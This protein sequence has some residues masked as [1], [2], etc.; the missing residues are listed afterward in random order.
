M[1]EFDLSHIRPVEINEEAYRMFNV[2]AT[3]LVSATDG[4]ET[5]VMAATWC[6]N[7]DY[8]PT[9]LTVVLAKEHATRRLLENNP[10][11]EFLIQIPNFAQA[12]LTLAVGSVSMNDDAD[13]LAH[14]GV[15]LFD[16]AGKGRPFVK[17][18]CGWAV[19]KLIP[20][21]ANQQQYDLFIGE[22]KE[23]WADDRIFER[24]HW[25]FEF[26]DPQ[27]R[28]LHYV[29]GGRFYTIGEAIDVKA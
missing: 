15:E 6:C 16:P 18:C 28:T 1:A 12:Q 4:H 8:N 25:K 27:W 5:D 9:K 7:L 22:V 2:G 13:K 11:G 23:A 3:I 19:C 14:C 26:A 24:G 29:A 21:T 17:G 20:E 10:Q